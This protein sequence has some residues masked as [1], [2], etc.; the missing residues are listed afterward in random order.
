MARDTHRYLI[1]LGSNMRV[2]GIGGPR[3]VVGK[4]FMALEEKGLTLLATSRIVDSRPVGPSQRLYANAIALVETGLEPPALL[5]TLQ[6]IETRFGRTRRGQRWRARPLDLDI[7][8]W[9]GGVWQ[10]PGLAIPHP[11]FRERAFVLQPAARIAPRWRDPHTGLTL[12][13]LAAR[14]S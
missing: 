10:S 8:L 7:V 3:A 2:P 1:A 5:R 6:G 13:Q 9:S 14:G 12:R 4:A 11:H